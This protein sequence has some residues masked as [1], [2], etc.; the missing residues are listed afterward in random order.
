ML[1][2]DIML[3]GGDFMKCNLVYLLF[4]KL[5]PPMLYHV[6][7]FADFLLR[8]RDLMKCNLGIALNKSFLV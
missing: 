6:I 8:G 3:R 7:L 4:V 2:I 1:L 5:I